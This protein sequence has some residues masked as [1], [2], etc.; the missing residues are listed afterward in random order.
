MGGK[1]KKRHQ[2]LGGQLGKKQKQ[3]SGKNKDDDGGIIV[4]NYCVHVCYLY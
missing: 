3:V 4:Y 1:G 2:N